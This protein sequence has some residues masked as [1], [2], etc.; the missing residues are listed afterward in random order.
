MTILAIEFSSARRSV[1]LAH[2]GVVLAEA[3]AAGGRATHA[4]GLIEQVL[5]A[6]K[7]HRDEIRVIAVGMGPGSYTG[8]RAAIALA[9]GWQLARDIHLLAVSSMD[10]IAARAQAVNLFGQVNLVVDAQR[11]EFYLARWEISAEQRR[12]ISPLVI[13]PAAEV[14]QRQRAGEVVAGPAASDPGKVLFPVASAVALLGESRKD[15]IPGEKL[16]PIYLRETSFVKAL[17]P[18]N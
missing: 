13:V 10:A 12:E 2:G 15:F 16:A 6:S 5:A 9:Q 3:D 18:R 14:E 17:P 4:F 11:G 8:I 1:A 7:V